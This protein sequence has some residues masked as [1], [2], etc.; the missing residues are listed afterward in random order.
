[1]E[2]TIFTFDSATNKKENMSIN[3]TKFFEQKGH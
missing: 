2:K 1:M 3:F